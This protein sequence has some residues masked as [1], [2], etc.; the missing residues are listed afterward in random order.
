MYNFKHLNQNVVEITT[1]AA[2]LVPCGSLLKC[3]DG[4]FYFWPLDLPGKNS[5]CYSEHFMRCV[6]DKLAELNKDW[7]ETVKRELAP[8]CPGTDCALVR[9]TTNN[10]LE[11]VGVGLGEPK[12][13]EGATGQ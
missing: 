10:K 8:L 3:E 13:L 11:W 12:G 5:G 2:D 4:Y 1:G 6:A 7:D 9:N